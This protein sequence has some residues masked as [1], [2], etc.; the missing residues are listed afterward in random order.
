MKYLTHTHTHTHTHTY[1]YHS[2]GDNESN[3]AISKE[4]QNYTI[5]FDV[6]I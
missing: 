5:F 1:A 6:S 3:V 4:K 2:F